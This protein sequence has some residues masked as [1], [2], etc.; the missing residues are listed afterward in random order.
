MKKCNTCSIYVDLSEFY[1]HPCTADGLANRCKDCVKMAAKESRA[2]WL[3]TAQGRSQVRSRSNLKKRPYLVHRE[4]KCR[5]CGFIPENSCQLTVDH[6]D[7]NRKNNSIDNLQTLC[8]NCHNLKSW[9]EVVEPQRL[10][11]LN[12]I[13]NEKKVQGT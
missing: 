3:S 2:K 11:E 9:I 8:H 13:P 7:K 5:R 6:I 10:S 12:L 4:D 1:K